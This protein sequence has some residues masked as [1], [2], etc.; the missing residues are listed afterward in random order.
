ME[1][2]E[3]LRIGVDR[4]AGGTRVVDAGIDHPGSIEAGL[5]VA[6]ICLA[7]L[8]E[9]GL[10]ANPVFPGLALAGGGAHQPAGARVPAEPIRRLESE[11]GWTREE[12]ERARFGAGESARGPGSRSSRSSRYRDRAED[13]CLVLETDRHPPPALVGEGRPGLLEWRRSG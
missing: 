5:L 3:R 8:G 6:R 4:M 13:A 1:R 7:G 12:V 2:A 9:V 11:R 10:R